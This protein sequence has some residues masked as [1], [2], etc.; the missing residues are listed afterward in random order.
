MICT[1]HVEIKAALYYD[2]L[3]NSLAKRKVYNFVSLTWNFF[4]LMVNSIEYK[5]ALNQCMV[6]DD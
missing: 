4:Y 6:S 5:Q 1:S 2:K 3:H